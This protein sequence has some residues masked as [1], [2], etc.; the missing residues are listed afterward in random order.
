MIAGNKIDI[1]GAFYEVPPLS[2]G[3][4]ERFAPELQSGVVTPTLVID[5]TLAALQRNYPEMTRPQVAEMIDTANVERIFLAIVGGSGLE[6][7]AA[8]PG[9]RTVRPRR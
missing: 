9:K 6:Q 7:K 4:V 2:L 8:A 1:G 3:A 5:I